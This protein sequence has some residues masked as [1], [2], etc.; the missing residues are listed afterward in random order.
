MDI[1]KIKRDEELTLDK[2]NEFAGEH[3]SAVERKYSLLLK[4]YESDYAILHHPPKP[5]YKPDNR[6]VANFASYIV[7]TMTGF[8]TGIAPRITS[9][10]D[11]V[12]EYLHLVNAYNIYDD[13][14]AEECKYAAIYG[15]D[16]EILYIDE[17][18]NIGIARSSPLTSF[19][20]YDDSVLER[21]RGFV[22]LYK[23]A[24][25][26]IT[27]S[28]SDEQNVRYFQLTPELK[29]LGKERPHGFFG[30]PAVEY[31]LNSERQG[32]FEP[33]FTLINAY[34]KIMSEK[35]NDVDY[36]ADAYMKILGAKLEPEE[37][38][39]I[40]DDR[41]I[42]FDGADADKLIVDFL[43]KPDGDTT[44]EHMLDRL[45]KLIFKLSKVADISDETFG[46]S[47]GIA[48]KYKMLAMSNMAVVIE[49]KFKKAM[50]ERYRLVFSSPVNSLSEDD[51][52]KV[53]YQFT[54]NYPANLAEEAQIAAQLEGVIS[55][56]SQLKVLSI[57][58]DPKREI[59]QME[60]EN[61]VVN[62]LDMRYGE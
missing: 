48:L 25:D 21:K 53:E 14:I 47:S 28:V 16:Y 58:S 5:K 22:R 31:V 49:R 32:L 52:T 4:A 20:I 50:Q 30:V 54:R 45:E 26:V 23:D 59:E 62:P 36:F 37:A 2:I 17:R 1:Y 35:G 11:E 29:W 27:G 15:R 38:E 42:N 33:V 40:R 13:L 57:V 24:D 19:M 46:T 39:H 8:F 60:E 34:N 51:Y 41:I 55:K 6:L 43:Q 44:Q 10:D 56:E 12:N 7:D 61:S 18:G 3:R 9:A